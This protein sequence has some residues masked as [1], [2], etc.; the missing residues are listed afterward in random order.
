[1]T[2]ANVADFRELA[3]RRLPNVLFEYIDGGSYSETTLRRNVAD[4]ETIA[5]RQRVMVDMSALD[6]STTAMGQPLSMP[7]G[8]APVGLAG[9]YARRGETQAAPG[10]QGGGR[11]LLPVEHGGLRHGGGGRP[12]HALVPALHAEGPRLHADPA[13]Q[14]AVPGRRGPG[15]H[16]RP[17]IGRGALPRHPLGVHRRR[18]DR[19]RH[20]PGH[21]RPEPSG[22]DV[23]R[24]AARPPSHPGQYRRRHGGWEHQGHDGLD[25]GQLRPLGH[26]GRHRMGAPDLEGQDRHQGRA[27]RRRRPPCRVSPTQ[28]AP[29]SRSSWTAASARASMC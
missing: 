3:R 24:L 17:A 23:G 12:H 22:L 26:L 29:I 4:L 15:L 10:G 5:L 20:T 14:G 2:I 1:M 8:L 7:V 11:A 21:R 19:P 18:G 25:E 16:R 27:R 6:L 13:R 28:W 9:M